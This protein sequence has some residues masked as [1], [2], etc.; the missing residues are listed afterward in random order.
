[1][2]LCKAKQ[3]LFWLIWCFSLFWWVF[4]GY[5]RLFLSEDLQPCHA[6][7]I[8]LC[9]SS[10]L[11]GYFSFAQRVKPRLGCVR[12]FFLGFSALFFMGGRLMTVHSS[13]SCTP[14]S[15]GDLA[16][17]FFF[18]ACDCR[19]PKFILYLILPSEFQLSYRCYCSWYSPFLFETLRLD[20]F[21]CVCLWRAWC[22]LV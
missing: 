3:F 15:I 6:W 19:V 9:F 11:L 8:V 7:V 22:S 16:D 20:T 13:G 10:R 1:M 4:V 17:F 21:W 12:I 18:I 2:S 5:K 14:D